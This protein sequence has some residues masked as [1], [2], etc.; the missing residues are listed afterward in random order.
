MAETAKILNPSRK[1]LLPDMEASC[2][3]AESCEGSAFARFKAEHPDHMVISY[4]N[5]SAE[6]KALSDLICTSG[7]AE[8]LVRALPEEQKIISEILTKLKKKFVCVNGHSKDSAEFLKKFKEGKT[9]YLVIQIV[10][11]NAALDFP[12]I[13]NIIYYSLHDSYIYFEQSKYRIRRIG[14]TNKC[15]YYYLIVKG[16]VEHSRLMS[17]KNKKSFNNKEFEIYKRREQD[18]Y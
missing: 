14:Q 18:E 17:L 2:S 7:N 10:S 5:C 11:G 9:D 15:H 4:I 12:H 13:N 3:L 6:I 1:V 8:K 16:T